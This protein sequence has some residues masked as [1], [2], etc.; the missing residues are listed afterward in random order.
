MSKRAKHNPSEVCLCCIGF[1]ICGMCLTISGGWGDFSGAVV[2]NLFVLATPF[3]NITLAFGPS[4]YLQLGVQ[5]T[6]DKIKTLSVRMLDWLYLHSYPKQ[7]AH[8]LIIRTTEFVSV[9]MVLKI[10]GARWWVLVSWHFQ[11][12]VCSL[13]FVLLWTKVENPVS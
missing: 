1:T 3:E 2:P 5:I 10:S 6:T 8:L 4:H 13:T 9:Q 11:R 7:T 12:P